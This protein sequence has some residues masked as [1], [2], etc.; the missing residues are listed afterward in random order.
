MAPYTA[1]VTTCPHCGEPNSDRARYCQ[2]CG[3]ALPPPTPIRETRK[4]VTVVF[5]DVTGSTGLGERLDPETLRRVMARYFEEMATVLSR[6]G[7]NVEKFI[8]DAVLAVFGVPTL[9]ED[10]ALRAVRAATEMRGALRSLNEELERSYGVHL[11]VRTGVNTGEVVAGDQ[12]AGQAFVAGDALNV[13]ARLEQAA[14]PGEILIGEATHRLVRPAVQA[15]AIEPLSLRGRDE[16]VRA[17]RLLKVIASDTRTARELRSPMVGREGELT[18]LREAFSVTDRE[19]RCH[20]FTVLGSAGVG[21]S[22]LVEEALAGI[23]GPARVLTGRCLAYGEGI[24]FWPVGEIVREAAGISGDTE[25]ES[26]RAAIVDT[27]RGEDHAERIAESVAQLIGLAATTGTLEETFWGIRRFLEAT[28]RSRPLVVVL[29]DIH[30]AEPTFLDL[31]EYLGDFATGAILLVCLARRE[32]LDLRPSW[33]AGRTNSMT[34]TLAPL[35]EAESATLIGNLLGRPKLEDTARGQIANAS[36]GN[37]FFIEEILQVLIDDGML[38]RE[39]GHWVAA[40]DL[41]GIDVP[42]TISALLAARLERLGREE[43]A[44]AQR[45]SVVGK[46]F[47]WSAVAALTPDEERGDVGRHLQALVRKDLIAPEASTFTGEDAFRFRHLLIRDAAYQAIPKESRAD[48]HERF[49]IWIE[50]RVGDRVTEFEEI[51]GHHLE[52]A[53]RYLVELGRL[54]ERAVDL[55]V[56]AS[57]RLGASGRR[58]LERR[59]APAAVNLLG[60]AASLLPATHDDRAAVLTDLAEGL[61]D[62]GDLREAGRILTEASEAARPG[63]GAAVQADLSR[64]WLQLYTEPEGKTEAIRKAVEGMMPSLEKMGDE[65]SLARAS[66]LLVELDWMAARYAAAEEGLEAVADHAARIGDRRQEME[67]LTRLAA[68]LLYGPRP[69]EDAL[70]RCAEV[71]A[72]SAG[73][74]RV[75]AGLLQAEAQL[76]A[77]AG[78]FEGVRDTIGRAVT[79]LEDLGLSLLAHSGREVLGV[80]EMLAGDFPAAEAALRTAYET[81]E[82]MGERGWLS[83]IGAELARAVYAQGRYEEADRYAGLSEELGA[84]DD[85]A[86]R[87]PSL[88]VRAKV[89]ARR[90]AHGDAEAL[91]REAAALSLATDCLDL[92]GEAHMDLAEVLRLAGR[93]EEAQHHLDAAVR[94]F[95][96]KGNLVSTERAR[97]LRSEVGTSRP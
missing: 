91:A 14:L 40:A 86:T 10:D 73:D 76:S 31:V 59:D 83:T 81:L 88:G 72:R 94:E 8:G 46:V 33:G 23:E 1:A 12:V 78:R 45:A 95:E 71:R 69:V 82:R 27:L 55:G 36:E 74:R 38:A 44:V 16:A 13:A 7:G 57:L 93:P 32:L 18:L 3:R 65:Q 70:R 96:A 26:A 68:A 24:T 21:K 39:D 20:L 6:H 53:N 92:R 79:I 49:A 22:R 30:W 85:I 64:L 52:Q 56:R 48:L 77:M 42:P 60:R 9:H 87:V 37:P 75:E 90:G 34:I 61:L 29:D 54:D 80:V 63:S 51:I 4:T 62:H 35:S 2:A 5:V 28:A 84:S 15:E 89:A 11:E 66:Y 58:A 17:Y 43:R 25:P 50:A 19:A 47:E 41:G 67:A 97:S